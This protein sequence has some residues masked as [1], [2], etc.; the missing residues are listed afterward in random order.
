MN[1]E[2]KKPTK[3]RRNNKLNINRAIRIV[4]RRGV[5]RVIKEGG[6]CVRVWC[7]VGVGGAVVTDVQTK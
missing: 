2:T 7:C 6:V 5:I 4:G 1:K 3:T